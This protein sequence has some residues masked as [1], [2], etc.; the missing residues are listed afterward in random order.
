[1]VSS[2]LLIQLYQRTQWVIEQETDGLTHEDSL[3]QMPFRGNC[4][5]W[6]LGHLLAYRDKVLELLAEEPFLSEEEFQRYNRE[7]API[8]P[9]DP[10]IPLERILAGL[11]DTQGRIATALKAVSPEMLDGVTAPGKEQ[12]VRERI[13]FVQWHETYHV[14][15]LEYLRQLAG[16]NDAII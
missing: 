8:M 5:N 2:S 9:G 6:V 7:S 15:Q 13:E 11:R 3:L 16:K 1:M 12:T 14:G 10:A 4:M